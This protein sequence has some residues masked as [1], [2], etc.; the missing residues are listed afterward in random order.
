MRISITSFT[1]RQCLI[2]LSAFILY[3][4]IS[5]GQS[6]NT[7]VNNRVLTVIDSLRNEINKPISDTLKLQHLLTL[8]DL[9][10]TK[11]IAEVE[12]YL[13]KTEK[14]ATESGLV[15]HLHQ[16]YRD[17][18][19]LYADK[20]EFEKAV[21]YFKKYDLLSDS[22]FN[23]KNIKLIND[24]QT[25]HEIEKKDKEIQL[26]NVTRTTSEVL[27]RTQKV[28]QTSSLVSFILMFIISL[29]LIRNIVLKQRIHKMLNQDNIRLT[30][31]N[32]EAKYE[33]L[34]SKI[35]PHFL[36]NSLNTLTSIVMKSKE[37]A[38]EFIRCF[39]D[40]YRMVMETENQ[41]LINLTEEM[42]LVDQYLYLQKTRFGS[43]LIIDIEQKINS[44]EYFLPPFAIQMSVENA[45]KHNIISADH[46][47]KLSIRFESDFV[48]IE[49]NLQEKNIE[50]ASTSSGQKNIIGRYNLITHLKPEFIKENGEFIVMLPI[51]ARN[52]IIS[53]E[54]H[55]H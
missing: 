35:N 18:S 41:K 21:F 24:I 34:K 54:L 32:L 49:N 29:I 6:I 9:Y 17:L 4:N 7:S 38:T 26:L 50:V 36:F 53:Y 25:N 1:V 8:S 16:I 3:I 12:K 39:T 43:H 47:L 52:K 10:K 20:N 27:A 48:V 14:I 28:T 55:N 23:Q 2:L 51:L 31:E 45:I 44:S 15:N 13:I 22:I 11:N 5:R 40:L 46:P 42:K 19:I 37:E 33:V 30:N